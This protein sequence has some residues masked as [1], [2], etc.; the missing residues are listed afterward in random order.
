MVSHARS[1]SHPCSTQV[2]PQEP[3]LL[4]PAGPSAITAATHFSEGQHLSTVPAAKCPPRAP[5]GLLRGFFALS[6]LLAL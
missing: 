4:S 2:W 6:L 5:S 3:A 1:A